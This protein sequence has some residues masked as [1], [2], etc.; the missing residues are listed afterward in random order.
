M[1]AA[2]TEHSEHSTSDTSIWQESFTEQ[3]RSQQL[4]DDS[5]AWERVTGLLLAVISIGLLLAITT[6]LL[7]A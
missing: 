7:T 3:D 4:T 2:S 6:V 1:N 5:Q